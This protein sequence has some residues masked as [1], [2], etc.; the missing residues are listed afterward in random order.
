MIIMTRTP[1]LQKKTQTQ[2]SGVMPYNGDAED[3]RRETHK[4]AIK[5]MRALR[6]PRDSQAYAVSSIETN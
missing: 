4:K 1:T 2:A 5:L 3:G 6:S